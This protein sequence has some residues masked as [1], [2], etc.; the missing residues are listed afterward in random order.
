MRFISFCISR[1][2]LMSWL[3]SAVWVPLPLAM[4][5]RREPSMMVGSLRSS[6][7]IERMMASTRLTCASSI[8]ALRI[9]L[10]MPGIIPMRFCRG[11]ILRTCWSWSRKSSSVNLPSSSLAAAA[12]ASSFS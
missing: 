1:N 8:S 3:T 7:V 11:P 9:S 10:G 4:R 6:R 2:C 12:S 5:S